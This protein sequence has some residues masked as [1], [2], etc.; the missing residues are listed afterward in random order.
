MGGAVK[1]KNIYGTFP[2]LELGGPDDVS[3]VG[4]FL[5]TTSIS[6]MGADLASW[7]GVPDGQLSTIFPTLGNFPNYKLGLV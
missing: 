2:T 5:P 1:G 6:Q 3:T 4:R 7:F